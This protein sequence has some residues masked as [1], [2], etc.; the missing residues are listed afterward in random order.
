[1][2]HQLDE[3]YESPLHRNAKSSLSLSPSQYWHRQCFVGA[4]FVSRPECALRDLI[5]V[6]RMMWGSD[7]PHLEGTWPNS[8]RLMK[9]SF[10]GVPED[11]VR[12]MCGET[13]V[14]VY[15][16]DRDLLVPVAERIGP[17]V[18]D[19]VSEGPAFEELSRDEL[20]SDGRVFV[21]EVA[22]RVYSAPSADR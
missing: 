1:M 17:T 20:I 16:L 2:L 10:V 8:W 4:T 18:D 22:R 13:A 7:Y 19:L 15:R 12:A 14:E 3:Q 11:E 9:E 6:D 5:G 21:R